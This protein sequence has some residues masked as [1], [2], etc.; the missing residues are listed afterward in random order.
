MDKNGI[1]KI[2]K[3]YLQKIFAEGR[4]KSNIKGRGD[5]NASFY[6]KK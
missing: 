6:A 2:P 1:K 3:A 5:V 4:K